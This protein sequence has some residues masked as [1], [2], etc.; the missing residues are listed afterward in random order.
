[1]ILAQAPSEA[2][3]KQMSGVWDKKMFPTWLY[4]NGYWFEASVP[5]SVNLLLELFQ[6]SHDIERD[7]LQHLPPISL[8]IPLG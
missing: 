3:I 1:V 2:A 7:F 4:S 5:S 8:R 6:G